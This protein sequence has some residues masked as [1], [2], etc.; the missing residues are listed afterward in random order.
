LTGTNPWPVVPRLVVAFRTAGC[1]VAVL[2]PNQSHRVREVEG[3]GNVFCYN[4]RSPLHSLKTAIESFDPDIVI[5]SCDRSV[6]HLHDLHAIC[7]A[8]DGPSGKTAALIER[9]LGS[10]EAFSII[11]SR[12]EL[13]RIAQSEGILV[14]KTA[15]ITS[16]SDLQLWSARSA[17]P[18][19]I[20]AD[21]TWGGQGVRIAHHR[22]DAERF[23]E[24]FSRGAGILSL[25]KNLL[26]NR[27]RDWV[28][29]DWRNSRHSA[30]AQSFIQGR[31]ANCAVVCWQGK[32]LASIA[33]EVIEA[34]GT[35]G[36]ATMVQLVPGSEM[37]TAAEKIARRLSISGFFGL[38]FMIE[39]G[40][41]AVYLIEMNPRCT[42]PCALPLGQGRNLVAAFYAQLTGHAPLGQQPSITQNVIA[43]SSLPGGADSPGEAMAQDNSIHR[44]RT[45]AQA[46]LIQRRLHPLSRRSAI[47]RLVDFLRPKQDHKAAPVIFKTEPLRTSTRKNVA[48]GT[49]A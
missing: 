28:M 30:V 48:A 47:G 31:P 23:V 27:G 10:A 32:V 36:P 3:I 15:A 37:T 12:N 26:L 9:S 17:P 38:D 25:L 39:E 14:P 43:Y 42:P 13:L 24:E 19:V 41:G 6:Q 1:E 46:E 45:G 34:R 44:D 5:P 2:Y 29:C 16:D 18:W 11:S 8:Q 20:K 33:V 4:G 7:R 40:S 21:G 35:T 49:L 22:A